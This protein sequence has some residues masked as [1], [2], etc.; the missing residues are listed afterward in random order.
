[1]IEGLAFMCW[2]SPSDIEVNFFFGKMPS[3]QNI[4][5]FGESR[6]NALANLASVC[7]PS[8]QVQKH[9]ELEGT[10]HFPENNTPKL[11]PF[12]LF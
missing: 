12:F 6:P 3:K 2:D 8:K 7:N 5:A 9:K 4:A 11:K 1:M 10:D